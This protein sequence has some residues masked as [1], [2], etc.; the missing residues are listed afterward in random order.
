MSE[1]QSPKV[2]KILHL[3]GQGAAHLARYECGLVRIAPTKHRAEQRFQ[4]AR[5]IKVALT[6]GELAQLRRARSGV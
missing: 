3:E 1:K 4:E 6:P 5:A 2:R